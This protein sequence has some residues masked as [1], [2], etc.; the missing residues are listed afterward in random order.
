MRLPREVSELLRDDPKLA[1]LAERVAA[2]ADEGVE[3]RRPRPRA[4]LVPAVVAAAVAAVGVAVL[5]LPTG[6]HAPSL[7]ERALA[8]IGHE[9]V[10]HAVVERPV[11]GNRTVDLTTGR[12][13]PAR[14]SV[15]SWFDARTRRLHVIQRRNGG[16]L[17]DVLGTTQALARKPGWRLDPALTLFLTGYR[18]ALR[19]GL[20]GLAPDR[21]SD[22]VNGR[23][24]RWLGLRSG[25][26]VAVEAKTFLPVV[27]ERR[28]GTRWSIARIES[29]R[30]S[31][32]DF[33]APRQQPAAPSGGSV[34]GQRRISPS[35]AARAL[36]VPALWLGGVSG[37]LHLAVVKLE[38]LVSVYPPGS[39]RRPVRSRG[40]ALTYRGPRGVG[41]VV[42]EARRPLPAYGFSGRLTFAFDPVPP[43]GSLQLVAIGGG[44]LGQL[45]AQRLYIT[46]AG[47]DAATLIRAARELRPITR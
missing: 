34:L 38:R 24:V 20:V 10:L 9:R 30:F 8:A 4:L 29:T 6:G 16:V 13:L 47:P 1:R 40:L 46:L 23:R 11:D 45:R 15:E 26:R 33:E 36:G 22:V 25:E 31:S 44:W 18:Q 12:Q 21:G 3:A 17:A 35:E 41:V 28:D 39:R 7:S 2:L 42:R 5:V 32:A 43:E 27:I 14:L 37:D 19:R